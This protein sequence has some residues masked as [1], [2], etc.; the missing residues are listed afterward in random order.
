MKNIIYT[1]VLLLSVILFTGCAEHVTD[2]NSSININI[3]ENTKINNTII[4]NNTIDK[5]YLVNDENNSYKIIEPTNLSKDTY[6]L[7]MDN[8]SNLILDINLNQSYYLE[9]SNSYYKE[10]NCTLKNYTCFEK[11]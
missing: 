1:V 8:K 5:S 4:N 9:I 3:T 11:R 6:W 10:T 2:V 7:I